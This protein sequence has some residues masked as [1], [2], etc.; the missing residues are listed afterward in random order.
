MSTNL[1][2]VG[3]G[4]PGPQ[5]QVNNDEQ[6]RSALPRTSDVAFNVGLSVWGPLNTPLDVTPGNIRQLFGPL[7]AGANL[8]EFYSY[9][10]SNYGRRGKAVRIAGAAAAAPT[11][12]MMDRLGVDTLTF[13]AKYPTEEP[14]R[15]TIQHGTLANTVKIS[16][17]ALTL[18]YVRKSYDNVKL[19]F[20][21]DEQAALDAGTSP[22]VTIAQINQ[23]SP[24]IT[25]TDEASA[26]AA[27]NNLPRYTNEVQVVTIT[28][29]PT[30]GTHTASLNRNG[31]SPI[32]PGLAYNAAATAYRAA[33]ENLANIGAGNVAVSGAAGGPYTV[34]FQN[35]LA[36][37][38]INTLAVAHAFTGGTLPAIGVS[39]SVQ[40]GAIV[41]TGGDNGFGSVTDAT[42]IGTQV[43]G[44][45]TGLQA[46][47]DAGLGKGQVCMFGVTTV[48][49]R[50]A[51]FEHC[52]AYAR[53]AL[54]DL[55]F[56]I[57]IND[58]ITLRGA[59]DTSNGALYFPT[60][61]EVYDASGSGIKKP[62]H[63]SPFV[64]GVFAEAERREGIGRAPANIRIPD[65]LRVGTTV[66]GGVQLDAEL[67]T[68]LSEN[69]INAIRSMPQRGILVYDNWVLRA[70]G[71]VLTVHEQRVLNTI[72][73]D[74]RL[75]YTDVEF[76][77]MDG[78][79][80]L[81]REV[82]SVT[83][84]YLTDLG[85]RVLTAFFVRCDETNNTPQT[86]A[87]QQLNVDITV[88]IVGSARQI[89]VR[90]NSMSSG[91]EVQFLEA[92]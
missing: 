8:V 86:M 60:D 50:N 90:L 39:T 44:A 11:F 26:S 45:K 54:P 61:V 75:T 38:D 40:G 43:D 48:A 79:G 58:A 25:I 4:A 70:S 22:F 32:T 55:P 81:M 52:E 57:S 85:D 82:T 64:A 49:A 21:A 92:A 72:V 87:A 91:T 62:V 80:R 53:F 41:L 51:L 16:E 33:L 31:V 84:Q 3:L 37:E 68:V 13:T 10:F 34:A 56:A 17:E 27:P 69:Q 6:I 14:I 65:A 77:I 63:T 12:T 67:H 15:I 23:F 7:R 18:G 35:D 9:F 28:G 1:N 76:R 29:S 59:H 19:T 47:N 24:L 20:T 2:L 30:G 36:N 73:N 46:F 88:R 78:G 83:K 89:I 5:F 42:Y 66:P 74:L 71:R